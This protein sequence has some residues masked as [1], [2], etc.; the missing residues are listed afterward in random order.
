MTG[1][2]C[3]ISFA[4]KSALEPSSVFHSALCEL[5][6]SSI[7]C[8]KSQ[9]GGASQGSKRIHAQLEAG[10]TVCWEGADR[11]FTCSSGRCP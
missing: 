1:W 3:V 11:I 10:E 9:R 4:M 7:C 5:H 6:T 8:W 2:P